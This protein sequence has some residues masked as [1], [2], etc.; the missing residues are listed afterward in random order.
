MDKKQ[1]NTL[2]TDDVYQAVD[3]YRR[4]HRL[5]YTSD[6]G[7]EILKA[8]LSEM[9]YLSDGPGI[10]PARRLARHVGTLLFYVSAT[11]LILSM[12]QPVAYLGPA[13]GIMCGGFAIRLVDYAVLRSVEPAVSNRLPKIEMRWTRGPTK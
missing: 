8:G 6:A 7:R 12:T 2:V 5:E 4:H 3:R 10:T 11:L 9:G 1:I 13:V